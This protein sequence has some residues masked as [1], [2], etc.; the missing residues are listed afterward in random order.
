MAR[1]KAILKNAGLQRYF[2]DCGDFSLR[3]FREKL[4][5]YPISYELLFKKIKD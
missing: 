1:P 4:S 2:G 5:A 3:A